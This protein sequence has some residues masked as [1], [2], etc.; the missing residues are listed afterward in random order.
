MIA[1]AP[2]HRPSTFT[3]MAAASGP[4]PPPC[5]RL[6]ARD[7]VCAGPEEWFRLPR[8][9]TG[10]SMLAAWCQKYSY[11]VTKVHHVSWERQDGMGFV[12]HFRVSG[13]AE[14]D[15]CPDRAELAPPS[16]LES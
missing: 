2:A 5:P 11:A 8:Q 10:G 3:A 12:C 13:R 14:A 15:P 1:I 16:P 6:P 7:G 4:G 9:I